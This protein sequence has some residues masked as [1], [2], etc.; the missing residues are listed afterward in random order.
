M[1]AP[2]SNQPAESTQKVKLRQSTL[3]EN[4]YEKKIAHALAVDATEAT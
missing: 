2:E 3:T 4:H 1:P